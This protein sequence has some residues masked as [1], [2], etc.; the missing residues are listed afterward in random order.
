MIA[1]Q[2][3]SVSDEPLANIDEV[4]AGRDRLTVEQALHLYHHVPLAQLGRW[5]NAVAERQH[6]NKVR[7]Y[8]IDRNI[9]YTNVCSAKC[10]FCAFRRDEDDADS[11]T[12]DREALHAKIAELSDIGGKQILLQ[13]G[14]H[15]DLPLAFYED[16]LAGIRQAFPHIH[17]HAFSPPEF[18]EF[19]AVFDIPGFPT[20]GA[21]RAG[22]LRRDVFNA[23]LEAIMKRL[24]D[25]GLN[26]LPG[27][28]GEILPE[29]VGRRIG[30]TKAT[31]EQWLDVMRVAHKLG[32]FTSATMMF[33]H[34][35]GVADRLVHMK[36]IRDAQDE[37]MRHMWPGR[38][39]SFISWPFQ[40]DN[41]PLGRLPHYDRAGDAAFP[42]DVLADA[43]FAGAVDPFDKK[44]C[45]AASP[46]AGK[47]LRLAGATEYLR[48]QA[49][50]RLF[51]DN[52]HSI[53][54]SWVTMGPKI[55]QI[56]LKFGANDMGSVM[57]EE[58]VV[59]AAGTTYCLTEATICRLIRAAGYTPA[60]RDNV[61]RFINVHENEGPDTEVTDWSAYRPA[62]DS[63]FG[64][65]DGEHEVE[66]TL[67]Q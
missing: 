20:P 31:G 17:L 29:N 26:S 42:G 22:D 14:M 47:S 1:P 30:S 41:T 5:A 33:G 66:L 65:G 38:Y 64:A 34:I 51:M 59:S 15:P 58:N 60:E 44:A 40:P 49:I 28:G 48:M 55:G 3:Q 52:F 50:S 35:E 27:G 32:M 56:G 45:D 57:M 4:V 8:V 10:T 39:V 16:M 7:T 24:M 6:G 67:P 61:Y 25:A 54:A 23:K 12:L 19:V 11:Y 62:G 53:G 2:T 46:A 43:V 9:N 13:G 18:V 36:M 21:T 63:A 37:A